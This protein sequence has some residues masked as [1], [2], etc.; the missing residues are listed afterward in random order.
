MAMRS[1]SAPWLQSESSGGW[2]SIRSK[3]SL[4]PKLERHVGAS[5]SKPMPQTVLHTMKA[6]P[7]DLLLREPTWS[8]DCCAPALHEGGGATDV[9]RV[10][11]RRTSN[12]AELSGH[13]SSAASRMLPLSRSDD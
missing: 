5:H 2:N 11:L 1:S 3:A 13:E 8:P 9:R 12:S 6:S 7:T 10:C 4:E